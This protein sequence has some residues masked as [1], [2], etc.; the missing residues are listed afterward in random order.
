MAH[1]SC[2]RSSFPLTHEAIS[3]ML[4]V[5]R[6][7][8][9]GVARALRARGLLECTRGIV[10]VLNRQGLETVACPCYRVVREQLDILIPGWRR[11]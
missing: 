6:P 10:N 7:A 4:G 11:P 2:G 9:T 5:Y 3:R 1:D 8:V